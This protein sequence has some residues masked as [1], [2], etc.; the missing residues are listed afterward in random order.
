MTSQQDQARK[1][2]QF[3]TAAGDGLVKVWDANSGEAECTLDNHEDRV[4]AVTVHPETNTIVS[5]SGDSTVTFWKDTTA[6][7]QAAASQATLKVIEQEQ[8]LE[9]HIFAGSYREAI[10][11]ALQLN[12]PGRLLN[13]FTSVVT[14]SKPDEGSLCGIK[15][16]DEVLGSLSDEQIFLLLLR[17]RD[18]NTNARTAPVAQRI[19][20][21]LVRSYPASKFSNLSVKGARGQRSLK[22]VLQGLRVY[23]ERHYKRMEELVDESYLVE[24]TL[25]E[26]D[27][28]AP[29][30][31]GDRVMGDTAMVG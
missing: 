3:V 25:Q 31:D 8:E 9:N 10:T 22:D 6:E 28:L 1:K 19:L 20:W 29:L 14:N 7:T 30:E 24:Y 2:V 17:L 26:M 18:W 12:H 15:A 16:V 23:T 5:G 27:S 21:A 13:L 11:L 4:W